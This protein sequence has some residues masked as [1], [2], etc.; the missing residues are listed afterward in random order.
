MGATRTNHS[1][2]S[3]SNGCYKNTLFLRFS[4]IE[5]L[6]LLHLL[7]GQKKDTEVEKNLDCH[8]FQLR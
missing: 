5:A 1:R 7:K 8:L 4:L 2:Y 6:I 3:H